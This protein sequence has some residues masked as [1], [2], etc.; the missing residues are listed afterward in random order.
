[1]KGLYKAATLVAA[2]GLLMTT[3]TAQAAFSDQDDRAVSGTQA[4]G[5]NHFNRLGGTEAHRTTYV[6]RNFGEVP[7][8]IEQMTV[9]NAQGAVI[10]S[11][12][13][14]SLPTFRNNV[15]SAG[16]NALMPNESAQIRDRKSVV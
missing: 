11:A 15:L 3:M 13:G 16:D 8:R 1:M 9:Y 6:L 14:A 7:V 12:N 4:C 2:G 5:G 10:F